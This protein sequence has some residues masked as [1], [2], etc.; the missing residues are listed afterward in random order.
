MHTTPAWHVGCCGVCVALAASR[1]MALARLYCSQTAH[2][3]KEPPVTSFSKRRSSLP[4]LPALL[5]LVAACGDVAAADPPSE[6][7]R[8]AELR[9][10][11]PQSIEVPARQNWVNTGVFLTSGQTASVVVQGGSWTV[12]R[13]GT[14]IDHGDCRIGDLVARIGLHYKDPNL[15]CV[16]GSATV[17]AD[18]D[19]I[20]F[21][22]AL[23]ENDLGETYGS[24][25]HASGSITVTV[26]SS[27]QPVPTLQASEA[28]SY[29]FGSVSSG[30]VEISGRHVILT[31]PTDIAAA[32]AATILRATDRLDAIYELHERLRGAVPYDGQRLRFFPDGTQ[33]GYMLAGNPV[34]MDTE[35]VYGSDTQRISRAGES[36][37]DV[38]GFAHEMGHAFSFPDG[39]WAY[40]Q[41]SLESWPNVFTLHA[42]EALGLP[43]MADIA[44][45]NASSSGRY[46]RG[47]GEWSAWTGLCF[48]MQLQYR[49][50]WGLYERFF[51]QLN[52][53]QTMPWKGDWETTGWHFVHDELERAAG[54]DV[55]PIFRAWNVPH[56]TRRWPPWGG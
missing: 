22:G 40:Q 5:S 6:L 43:P 28:A 33:V 23:T 44:D 42:F 49:H 36:G 38:W 12:A 26:E 39:F 15:T 14:S 27:G 19:G 46:V 16:D 48:L 41:D 11:A 32:D 24:R 34:R 18:K 7:E 17:T 56:P 3:Y 52:A 9:T 30:W 4:A 29:P 8:L 2:S 20:L 47:E 50:G 55:T 37:T 51:A 13:A 45:C 21:L 31:L 54:R 53:N 1:S 25:L 10:Y 35:L